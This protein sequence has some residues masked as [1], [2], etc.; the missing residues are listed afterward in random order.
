YEIAAVV[1]AAHTPPFF[2]D[3]RIVVA[4]GVGRFTADDVA[5]LVA[6]L[7]DPLP[8]TSVVLV[9]GGGQVP[10]SLLDAVKKVGDQIDASAPSGRK[11]S[12]WV[13]RRIDEHDVRLE[14]GAVDFL[15]GHLGDDLGRLASILDVLLAAH[16]TEARLTVDD[17]LPFVGEAGAVAP[18]D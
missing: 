7:G 17:V 3:R 9:G 12:A 13:A 6:Y 15:A 14:P 11:R 4:R 1:D 5:P 8:S 10:R 2:G 18:W 16:G